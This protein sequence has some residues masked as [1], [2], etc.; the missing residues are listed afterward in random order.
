[1]PQTSY[2]GVSCRLV[3][4]HQP[5]ATQLE[6]DGPPVHAAGFSRR[7]LAV[8]CLLVAA[9]VPSLLHLH[10]LDGR[11]PA[12]HNDLIGRWVGTRAALAG[13][14]PWSAAVLR[15]I[16]TAYYGRPLTPEDHARPQAFYYP[17]PIV[18]LLAPLAHFSWPVARLIFLA[19]A[20]PLLFGSFWLCLLS[21][22]ITRAPG[23]TL[24]IL[25]LAFFSWPSIWS[26]RLQQPTLIVAICVFIAWYALTRG[27]QIVPGALLSLT[28]IKP[29]LVFP[30]LAFLVFW[31]LLHRRW[32][33]LLS[34]AASTALLLFASERIVPGW[35]PH[36]TA[37]LRAYSDATVPPLELA[38]GHWPG[39]I[40]TLLLATVTAVLLWRFRHCP[41]P[42][43]EFACALSLALGLALVLSPTDAPMIYNDVL[44]FPACIVLI[45]SQ[46]TGLGARLA[47]KVSITLIAFR[48]ALV[49]IAVCGEYVFG[50]SDLWDGMPFLNLIL[51]VVIT[52]TLT[53]IAIEPLRAQQT[54]S[55]IPLS[56]VTDP[57]H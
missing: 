11:M 20:C 16:Q 46:P 53:W 30:L 47:R 17:A 43:Q 40:L 14:D 56:L 5:M 21:L 4:S 13:K 2:T 10:V 36:W 1:M 23:Q 48:Y 57:S 18:V 25:L 7:R 15:Q 12:T 3:Y 49:V 34:L 9:L 52:A 29:Q 33:F 27:H 6:L 26:L 32:R 42:S 22:P 50:P 37:S 54:E 35:F 24:T 19:L 31:S 45:F 44:L 39:L 51:P 41:Y 28:L 8:A 55:G 38:F